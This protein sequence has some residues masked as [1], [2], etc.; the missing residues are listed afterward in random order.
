MKRISRKSLKVVP[1]RRGVFVLRNSTYTGLGKVQIGIQ[2]SDL[3]GL[4]M[5]S[6]VFATRAIVKKKRQIKQDLRA[7]SDQV[8]RELGL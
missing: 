3:P 5:K 7:A 2:D 8:S 1:T 4:S 6:Y